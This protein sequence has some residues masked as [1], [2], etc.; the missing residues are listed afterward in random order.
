MAFSR[1]L[2]ARNGVIDRIKLG[3]KARTEP[4]LVLFPRQRLLEEPSRGLEYAVSLDANHV[5]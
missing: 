1:L 5:R 2:T 3:M 4:P